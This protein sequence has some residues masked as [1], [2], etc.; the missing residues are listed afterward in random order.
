MPQ[1][2]LRYFWCHCFYI[3]KLASILFVLNHIDHSLGSSRNGLIHM[4]LY[5]HFGLI[6]HAEAGRTLSMNG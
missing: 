4:G 5:E 2:R 3:S 1:S 6:C